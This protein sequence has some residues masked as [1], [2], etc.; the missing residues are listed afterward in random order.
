MEARRIDEKKRVGGTAPLGSLA[1]ELMTV[2][3]TIHMLILLGRNQ[4]LE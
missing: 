1:C 2:P 4:S 3:P